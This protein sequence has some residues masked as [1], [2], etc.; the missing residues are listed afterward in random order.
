MGLADNE[1]AV[2]WLEQIE[3]AARVEEFFMVLQENEQ[4][5]RVFC[6]LQ[7]SWNLFIGMASCSYLGLDYTALHSVLQMLCIPRKTWPELFN[8]IRIM[9]QAALPLLNAKN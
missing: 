4:T 3:S 5:I 9:E 1:I 2:Q 7:N 8:D 6:A